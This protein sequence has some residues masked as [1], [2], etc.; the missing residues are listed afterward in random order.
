MDLLYVRIKSEKL[1]SNEGVQFPFANKS[2]LQ[3]AM[4]DYTQRERIA[5]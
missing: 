3:L 1:L 2:F 5:N 4:W